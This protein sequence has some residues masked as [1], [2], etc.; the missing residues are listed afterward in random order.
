MSCLFVK[1]DKMYKN[2]LTKDIYQTNVKIIVKIKL[3]YIRK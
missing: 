3:K 2:P 1:N